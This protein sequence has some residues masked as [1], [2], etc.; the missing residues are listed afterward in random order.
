M[1]DPNTPER[2]D[3]K[4]AVTTAP[5]VTVEQLHAWGKACDDLR[6]GA[7]YYGFNGTGDRAV[8]LILSAVATAGKGAHHTDDWCETGSYAQYYGADTLVDLI[9]RA[10]D[11]AAADVR[12]LRAA[13]ERLTEECNATADSAIEAGGQ[14]IAALAV[15]R[16][17][18][19]EA[20]YLRGQA[21]CGSWAI[22]HKLSEATGRI[23]KALGETT[24]G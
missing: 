16:D 8:D 5:Q 12:R 9:Q 3:L 23:R 20:E 17:L 13:V 10:A 6:M 2:I 15:C 4:T 21:M 22:G 1:A 11:W 19:R 18:E 24:D 7:Y 14:R